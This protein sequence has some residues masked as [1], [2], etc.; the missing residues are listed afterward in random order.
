MGGR[1]GASSCA[2]S[3]SPP[4]RHQLAQSCQ[5]SLSAE[6]HLVG[7]VLSDGPLLRT[8]GF[9]QRREGQLSQGRGVSATHRGGLTEA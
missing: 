4:A 5:A 7:S 1:G 2:A 3:P 6:E 9:G 8:T